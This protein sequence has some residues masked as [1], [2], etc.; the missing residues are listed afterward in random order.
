MEGGTKRFQLI[1]F[2]KRLIVLNDFL[3][4]GSREK[5]FQADHCGHKGGAENKIL[6]QLRGRVVYENLVLF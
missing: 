3:D 4:L 1:I 6:H 2:S 5:V